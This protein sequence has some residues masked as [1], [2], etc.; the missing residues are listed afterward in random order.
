MWSPRIATVWKVGTPRKLLEYQP[1][2]PKR[3]EPQVLSVGQEE[4]GP[5]QQLGNG[6][7]E[8]LEKNSR[9]T[10]PPKEDQTIVPK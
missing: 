9:T 7:K 6:R 8:S 3:I 10:S 4:I 1:L 2:Y 5:S